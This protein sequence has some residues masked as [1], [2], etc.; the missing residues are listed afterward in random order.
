MCIFTS[1]CV[2][3][4]VCVSALYILIRMDLYEYRARVCVCLYGAH[5]SSEHIH[6][7][8]M[9]WNLVSNQATD[10]YPLTTISCLSH[11]FFDIIFF[12]CLFSVHLELN[13]EK[14]NISIVFIQCERF[15]K[16]I[17][18]K[19]KFCSW[20]VQIILYYDANSRWIKKTNRKI[21]EREKTNQWDKQK[22]KTKKKKKRLLLYY[23]IS[24]QHLN[25]WR[26]LY[27]IYLCLCLC[28]C[29]SYVCVCLC[30]CG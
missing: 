16:K 21:S 29:I 25:C 12:L 27:C 24:K 1:A 15:Q 5:H 22:K 18:E 19:Q 23:S 13:K 10:V 17:L 6:V 14:T 20:S 28:L 7:K 3:A 26:W 4:R 11:L 30:V 8:S 9:N 2:C